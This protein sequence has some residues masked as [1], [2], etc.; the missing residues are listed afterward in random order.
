M[1]HPALTRADG[2]SSPPG[3]PLTLTCDVD[4]INK[5]FIQDIHSAGN[6]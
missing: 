5:F 4:E 3:V 6:L 1:G 2:R